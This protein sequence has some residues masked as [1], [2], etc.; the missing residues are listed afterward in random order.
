[1]QDLYD[2]YQ[3]SEA[4]V[5]LAELHDLVYPILNGLAETLG[6]ARVFVALVDP[7]REIVE[8]VVGVN[9]PEDVVDA[10]GQSVDGLSGPLVQA[11]RSGR[12]IHVVDV[13]EDTSLSDVLRQR[14][15]ASG[16]RACTVIPLMTAS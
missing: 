6:Y 13:A 9:V 5:R 14:C 15:R 8:G 2:L 10:M 3:R 16:L 11:M 1:M 4:A 12:L 7:E